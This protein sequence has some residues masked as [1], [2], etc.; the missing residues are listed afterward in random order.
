MLQGGYMLILAVGT[1]ILDDAT[2][3]LYV[4]EHVLVA[5]EKLR[6]MKG[7]RLQ[8]ARKE[9]SRGDILYALKAGKLGIL[10]SGNKLVADGISCDEEGHARWVILGWT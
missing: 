3:R 8:G 1:K 5:P 2:M 6:T 4:V 10:I 9:I 7:F